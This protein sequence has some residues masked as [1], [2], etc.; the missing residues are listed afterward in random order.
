MGVPGRVILWPSK[1][2]PSAELA[3]TEKLNE[4]LEARQTCRGYKADQFARRGKRRCLV[5]IGVALVSGFNAPLQSES[6]KNVF[7]MLIRTESY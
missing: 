6:N 1:A 5:S 7:Q 3:R 2:A 4:A